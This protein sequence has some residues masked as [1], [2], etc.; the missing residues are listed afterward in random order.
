MDLATLFQEAN[1]YCMREFRISDPWDINN[2]F[3][4]EWAWYVVERLQGA[5]LV[6]LD[7]IAQEPEMRDT[8]DPDASYFLG[9]AHCIVRYRSRLYD[10]ECHKGVKN[11]KSLPV[12]KNKRKTREQVIAARKR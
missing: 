11:W 6:W 9:P 5:E 7:Q 8:S 10:A 4:E 1:N 3:C 12:F 2:G